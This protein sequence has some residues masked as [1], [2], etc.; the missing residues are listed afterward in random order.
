MAT[1]QFYHDIDLVKVG[2]LVDARIQNVTSAEASALAA[3]L[4]TANTGLVVFDTTLNTIRIWDGTAFNNVSSDI[5]GDVIFKGVINPTNV[6]TVDKSNGYQYVVDTAGTLTATGITFSP[7]AQV[8]VGDIVLFTSATEATIFNR[9]ID[10]A[11]TD[12]AGIVEI[13]TQAEVD[14]GTDTSRVLTPATLAGSALAGDVA[15]NQQDIADNA[16]DIASLQTFT[17]EGTALTTTASDLAAAVNE[18]VSRADSDTAEIDALEAFVG[19]GTALTTTASDLAGA[20]NELVGRADSADTRISTSETDVASLQTFTG[21]GTA[22]DTVATDLAAAINELHGE[23]DANAAAIVG[24]DSDIAAN[25]AQAAANALAIAGNDSDIAALDTRITDVESNISAGVDSDIAALQAQVT[26]NDSDIASALSQI[27]GNDSDILSLEGRMTAAE[28]AIVGNDSDILSL[29]GRMTAAEAAVVGNDSDIA[30]NLAAITSLQ[31]FSGEGTALDTTAGDL[32]AAINEIHAEVDANAAAIVAN[33]GD[34]LDLQTFAGFGTALTT[35]ATDLAGA[36][37]ELQ[38][39]VEGNDSDIASLSGR[40]DVL[41]ARDHIKCHNSTVSISSSTPRSISHNL[42]LAS[43]AN[44]VV[45]VMD[46]DNTQ[47]SVD[48]EAV[49]KDTISLRSLVDLFGVKVTVM[50]K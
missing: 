47:I 29:A 43:P 25:A 8:E 37:N 13:A 18:L 1:K 23:V 44:F 6:G 15:Q 48:I 27:A 12:A 26:A 16:T 30:A 49:D 35:A 33:D 10:A 3:I 32:A 38:A 14:A 39:E 46:S 45:N 11:T 19:E 4:T 42:D 34:I 41:E 2:Q 50:G 31:T 21:E 22:L 40:V 36:V 5:E 7:D 24:N 9:N 28:T 20:V 17:G